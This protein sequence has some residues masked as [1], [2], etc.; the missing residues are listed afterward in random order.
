MP[1]VPYGESRFVLG[2]LLGQTLFFNGML[3]DVLLYDQALIDEQTMELANV[4]EE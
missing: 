4:P 2:S 3:D 1:R